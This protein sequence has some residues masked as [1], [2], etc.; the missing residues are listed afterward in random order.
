MCSDSLSLIIEACDDMYRL[1]EYSKA[2]TS[3]P[4]ASFQGSK[5]GTKWLADTLCA[6]TEAVFS[7]AAVGRI[8]T[9]MMDALLLNILSS[10]R[11]MPWT[12][13][14]TKVVEDVMDKLDDA[15]SSQL[16]LE[17]LTDA[18][19]ADENYLWRWPTGDF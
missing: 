7:F 13:G 3:I 8:P 9:A 16:N 18:P 4:G 11:F 15:H 19:A 10:R 17:S 12:D 6:E 5:K 1:N 2:G 14:L